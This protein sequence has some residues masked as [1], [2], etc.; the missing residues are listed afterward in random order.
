MPDCTAA[1]YRN[2]PIFQRVMDGLVAEGLLRDA[3]GTGT[4][5]V[6]RVDQILTLYGEVL[7][8]RVPNLSW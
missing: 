8:E 2:G 6:L 1:I 3:D 4:A 7:Q 5:V